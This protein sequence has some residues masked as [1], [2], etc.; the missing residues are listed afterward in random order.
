[1]AQIISIDRLSVALRN[2]KRGTLREAFPGEEPD[3][4]Q[5]CDKLCTGITMGDKDGGFSAM[6]A[7][8]I[9]LV[10]GQGYVFEERVE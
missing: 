2:K 3:F 8:P 6:F 7:C 9:Q 1:M 5:E 10:A 4:V